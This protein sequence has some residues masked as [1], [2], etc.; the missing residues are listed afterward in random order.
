MARLGRINL[1]PVKGMG[2]VHPDG[3]VLTPHG[4]PANRRFYLIDEDGELFSGFDHGPLVTVTPGYDPDREWLELTFP[5]GSQVGADASRTSDAVVTDFHGRPVEGRLVSGPWAEAISGFVG[6][7]VRL[8]RAARDGDGS[9]VE[10]LTLV[11]A[12]SVAELGSRGRHDGPLDARRFRMDLELDGCEPFEEDSWAGR[13]V[14]AGGATIRVLGPVPRCRVTTQSPDTGRKDWNTL[15]HIARF[16]TR[17]PGD[18]GIPFGMYARVRRPGAIALGDEVA[19]VGRAGL[20]P[21]T[22]AL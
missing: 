20:E 15:T 11:S 3:V 1:A 6:E 13:E 12:A 21:A 10:H 16:R 9:D 19:V 5:D 17:I 22:R 2:F 18:G 4:I 8:V 7:P 14:R